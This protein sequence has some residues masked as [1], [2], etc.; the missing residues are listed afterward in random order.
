MAATTTSTLSV[1]G[2]LLRSGNGSSNLGTVAA[3]SLNET[4]TVTASDLIVTKS[5][6]RSTVAPGET[7][8]F[9][10]VVRNQGAGQSSTYTLTDPVPSRFSSVAFSGTPPAG[11][12]IT[13]TNVNCAGQPT[14]AAGATRTY[15]I[16]AVAGTTT[17]AVTNTAT[18]SATTGESNTANNS[19]SVD[20]T[21]AGADYTVTKSA[22][23]VTVAPG[24]TVTWTVT[25]RN[26]GAVAGSTYT[27]TD[28]IP[29][30][31]T[32]VTA[33]TGCTRTSNTVTCANQ[34]GLPAGGTREFVLT[35]VAGQAPGAFTNTATVS[36]TTGETNTT[37]NSGTAAVTITTTTAPGG[38]GGPVTTSDGHASLTKTADAYATAPGARVSY[39]YT[40]R[41]NMS[42]YYIGGAGTSLVD[43]RCTAVTRGSGWTSIAGSWWIAPGRTA[44]YTCEATL[45]NTTVNTATLSGMVLGYYRLFGLL[46]FVQTSDQVATVSATAAVTMVQT[47]SPIPWTCAIPTILS[48][49]GTPGTVLGRQ[50]QGS[51]TFQTVGERST[52]TYNSIAF[53]TAD[54]LVYAVTQR[55]SPNSPRGS[56]EGQLATVDSNG[57]VRAVRQLSLA[58]GYAT[59]SLAYGSVR[60]SGGLFGTVSTY[61]QAWENDVY[62]GIN[63]GFFDDAG[64]YWIGTGSVVGSGVL[65]RVDLA[66]GYVYPLTGQTARV[67]SNDLT[68]GFGYAWGVRNNTNQFVRVNVGTGGITTLSSGLTTSEFPAT[69]YGSAWTY[70]NGSLGFN[71]NEGGWYRFEVRNPASGAPTFQ[72]VSTGAGPASFNNDGTACFTPLPT[73]LSVQKT[74]TSPNGTVNGGSQVTWQISVNNDGP[75]VSSGFTLIDTL[76]AG[77][78]NPTASMTGGAC[79]AYN[80]TTRTISCVSSG[81]IGPGESRTITITAT[82]PTTGCYVS[83]AT[84]QANENDDDAANDTATTVQECVAARINVVKRTDGVTGPDAEGA[85]A[86][87]YEV[88]VG[89]I[90]TSPGSYGQLVDVPA[91]PEGVL[92]QNVTWSGGPGNAGATRALAD[93]TR[94]GGF[95]VGPAGPTALPGG[96]TH[97]Y[98][99]TVSYRLATP[100]TTV[101]SCVAAMTPGHGLINSVSLPQETESTTDNTVCQDPPVFRVEK[102]ASG[103][104]PDGTPVPVRAGTDGT[105]TASYVVTVTNAGRIP[106]R[107]PAISDRPSVPGGFAVTQVRLDGSELTAVGGAYAIPAGL[108]ALAPGAVVTYPITVIGRAADLDAVDWQQAAT[109]TTAGPGRPGD[110]GLVNRVTMPGDADGPDNNDAC[111]PVEPPLAR[112]RV[113]KW[114]SRCDVDVPTCRI[115]GARFAIHDTDPQ[116]S[117]ASPLANGISPDPANGA[118]FTSVALTLGRDY[119]L[120]ETK[121]PSGHELL[122]E[123]IRFRIGGGGV[124]LA[125]PHLA[126]ANISVIDDELTIRIVDV[127]AG[128]LPEAGSRGPWPNLLLGLVLVAGA[129]LHLLRTSGRR[130]SASGESGTGTVAAANQPEK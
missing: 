98:A 20:V 128:A 103:T 15:A 7:V 19:G 53:N 6:S 22:S 13:G 17:G 81:S 31:F 4:V 32:S 44:T 43:D 48:A 105:V 71:R 12:S 33:P 8:T 102:V 77:F 45:N 89:S 26:S 86:V 61:A 79:A 23:P 42:G 62:G 59:S 29:A 85:Y 113:E 18:I 72:L 30:G 64:R 66:T 75:G 55:D 108:T 84:V 24:G 106:A 126:A 73:D 76:P 46:G 41:N 127:H 109:C 34:P 21:I 11:C 51:A 35:S 117:G 60:P 91:F 69:L 10:I 83:S 58:P 87:T 104:W 47:G 95:L 80:A 93:P 65:Y 68:F 39:T 115:P 124:Q 56:K 74:R 121:A 97:A 5:A 63:F 82:A 90:G 16:T 54:N 49:Y 78:T 70:G 129:G 88:R 1:S 116:T 112:I 101:S 28:P 40:I 100:A 96:A 38:S 25:V 92:V 9:T 2:L 122:P 118:L 130:T 27:L 36:N 114:G 67:E 125:D 120:V 37:N 57:T 110:G 111:V 107:H 119:W 99:V 14:L 50:T 3:V 123:A 94:P 52:F